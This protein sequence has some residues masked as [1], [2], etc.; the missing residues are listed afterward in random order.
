M[1]LFTSVT[2]QVTVV[3]P[4][5]KLGAALFDTEAIPQLSDVSGVPGLMIVAEH[6]PLAAFTFRLDGQAI[7]GS[8]LS[9]TVTEKLHEVTEQVLVAVTITFVTPVLNELP[10]FL[11]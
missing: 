8:W 9:V 7:V 3:F 4:T 11:E 5:G 1:L 2:V 6:R 10:E